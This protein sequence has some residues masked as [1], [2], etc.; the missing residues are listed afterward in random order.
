M[1]H[2]LLLTLLITVLTSAAFAMES[3]DDDSSVSLLFEDTSQKREGHML[4]LK[5]NIVK[6]NRAHPITLQVIC[7][8]KVCNLS[9]EDATQLKN[10]LLNCLES[11]EYHNDWFCSDLARTENYGTTSIDITVLKALPLLNDDICDQKISMLKALQASKGNFKV[12]YN[13]TAMECCFETKAKLLNGL[14]AMLTILE[15]HP[16]HGIVLNLANLGSFPEG[17]VQPAPT[18]TLRQ[19]LFNPT[20]VA[21]ALTS[22]CVGY[23]IAKQTTELP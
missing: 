11:V 3:D 7:D 1:K 22:L 8:G 10:A 13:N 23:V 19:H 18:L 4:V 12:F 17:I 16:K 9:E 15:K 14:A 2:F 21:I 6:L 20:T 5:N